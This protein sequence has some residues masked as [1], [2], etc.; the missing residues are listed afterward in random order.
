[1]QVT[2]G[3]L[4][5]CRAGPPAEKS[6]L[7]SVEPHSGIREIWA[8]YLPLKA[9]LGPDLLV[10][11]QQ[12]R[13]CPAVGRQIHRDREEGGTHNKLSFTCPIFFSPIS[14]IR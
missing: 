9:H 4:W 3:K 2:R 13:V 6:N 5:V 12:L 11:I 1:M 10:P 14:S 8:L 7:A